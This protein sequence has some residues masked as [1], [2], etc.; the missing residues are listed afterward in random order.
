MGWMAEM[1]VAGASGQ[2]EILSE[3]EMIREV[4][5]SADGGGAIVVN[6]AG[7]LLT[8]VYDFGSAYDYV[9]ANGKLAFLW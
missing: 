5:T 8:G 9:P 6:I 4:A 3:A 2:A 7:I 1:H